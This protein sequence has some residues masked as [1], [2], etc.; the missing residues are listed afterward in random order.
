MDLALLRRMK[1]EGRKIVAVVAWDCHMAQ[2]AE[3]AGAELVSVGDSVGV[4]LW[5]QRPEE[6][7]LEE[8]LVVCKAVRRGVVRALV[9]CDLPQPFIGPE[10]AKRLMSEGGADVVKVEGS[11][12]EVEALSRA[13]VPV[14]AEFHGGGRDPVEQAKALEAA[15]A[16]LLDFR[17]SGERDGAAVARAVS[18]PVLGGLGGGPWLDGRLRM[19]HAAIGYAASHLD[20]D[21]ETYANVA[22]V[23]LQALS[24]YAADVRAGRALKGQGPA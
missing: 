23:S 10:N 9:S 2:I 17:H 11:P 12:A 7:T 14:F 5:G 24:E 3:R 16:V 15:G 6:I 4:N 13:G 22:R 8:M 20:G 18:A 21:G 1:R 19:A